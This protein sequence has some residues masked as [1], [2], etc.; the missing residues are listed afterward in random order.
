MKPGM[1][2]LDIDTLARTA[3]T[4]A[5]YAEYMYSTGHALG[6]AAHDGGGLLGPL[7]ERYGETPKQPLEAGQVYTV[8]PGVAVP[9]YGYMGLEED[10]WVQ[11]NGAEFLSEPQTHLV[12]L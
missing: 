1:K 8:E 5:G 2:G 12:L 7:W 11:A 10:V 6:R 3:I 4:G 9:G